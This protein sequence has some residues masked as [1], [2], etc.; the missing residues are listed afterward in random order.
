MKAAA[1][2]LSLA[3]A[4]VLVAQQGNQQ[5][6]QPSNQR[7]S[8]SPPK[9]EA[10]TSAATSRGTL[11]AADR[12]FVEDAMRGGMMEVE[13]G[14]LAQQKAE[15]PDVRAFGQRMVTDHSKANADLV[16]LA[17][18]SGVTLAGDGKGK[19]KGKD[20]GKQA[21]LSNLNGEDFDRAYVRMMVADHQKDVA[22]FDRMSR[23]AQDAELKSF[24]S[25]TLP[26]LRSHLEQITKIQQDMNNS[27]DRLKANPKA[28]K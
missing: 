21:E 24:A 28:A 18:R 20:T 8:N 13:L 14:R 15:D 5:N 27:R 7:D 23:S 22:E 3:G 19:D 25:K 1:I 2:I 9:T 12:R 16:E 17:R 6:K 11:G 4:T 10:Q 26:T